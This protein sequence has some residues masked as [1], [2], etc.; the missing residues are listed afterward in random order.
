MAETILAGGDFMI[1]LD[2]LARADTAGGVLRAVA[3]PPAS[4]TFIA[5]A[6]RFDDEA[7]GDLGSAMGVLVRSASA[8]LPEQ[9]RAALSAERPTID[10][11]PTDIEVYGSKKEGV[12]YNY[13]GQAPA[14]PTRWYRPRPAWCWPPNSA[15][16]A[17][18]PGPRPHRSSPGRWPP[19][20]RAWPGPGRGPT[21]ASSPGG[22]RGGTSQRVRLR[23]RGQAQH[24][25]MAG[26]ASR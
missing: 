8:A 17:T 2:N 6:N 26:G 14:G 10:L 1:D 11:D 21:P 12:T 23:H 25:S 13:A 18:T 22:G 9:R 3:D 24:S 5:L 19:C 15:R 7:I 4:T 20:P 16:G